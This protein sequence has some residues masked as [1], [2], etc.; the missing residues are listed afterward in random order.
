MKKLII[1]LALL[2]PVACL[3][4]G[5]PPT[6]LFPG[7]IGNTGGLA[8]Q[9]GILVTT[10]G[11]TYTLSPFQ[12]WP[13]SLRIAGTAT[14]I[15]APKN[16]GQAY[17]VT[18]TESGSIA[19]GG[20]TGT[21]VT[22]AAGA[23]VRV[24]CSDGANYVQVGSSG[25]GASVTGIRQGNGAP[26]ADTA[27]TS[28]QIATQ[29]S[30]TPQAVTLASATLTGP[31]PMG[32]TA[33]VDGLGAGTVGGGS[34]PVNM[35]IHIGPTSVPSSYT[36]ADP[37]APPSG[38]QY[39]ACSGTANVVCNWMTAS[40]GAVSSVSNSD[41]TLTCSPTTGA[42]VC[43]LNLGHAN[44]WTGVQ[45]F[46]VGAAM[47]STA[48]LVFNGTSGLSYGGASATLKVGNGTPGD[49]S[50]TLDA[51]ILN[52]GNVTGATVTATSFLFDSVLTPGSCVQAGSGG[53]LTTP[54]GACGSGGGGPGTGTVQFLPYWNSSST[55]GTSIIYQQPTT[56]WLG[57]GNSSP[58]APLHVGVVDTNPGASQNP[59]V[60]VSQSIN[61]TSQVFH[62]YTDD[63]MIIGTNNQPYASYDSRTD[64]TGSGSMDHNGGYQ[65]RATVGAT[66]T[67]TLN[68]AIG[69]IMAPDV[70]CTAC[71]INSIEGMEVDDYT[72]VSGSP[73]PPAIYYGVHVTPLTHSTTNWAFYSD[74][75]ASFF[76]GGYTSNGTSTMAT[77]ASGN[78]NI[79][80][81]N[82]AGCFCFNF[83]DSAINAGNAL[84]QTIG[85]SFSPHNAMFFG[86]NNTTVPHATMTTY[87]VGDPVELLGSQ[88]W[89]NAPTYI[90]NTLAA[91]YATL[92][93][94][95]GV[96]NVG[97]TCQMQVDTS[98]N[99][100]ATTL[101]TAT[102]SGAA[103]GVLIAPS[104]TLPSYNL[105]SLNG[106]NTNTS[107]IGILGGGTAD[108]NLYLFNTTG[109]NFSFGTNNVG[110]GNL[111]TTGFVLPSGEVFGWN[112]DT[113]LSRDSAG[114]VD[115]G[116]GTAGNKSCTFNAA[117][118]FSG[119][120]GAAAFAMNS[121]LVSGQNSS[122]VQTIA[123]NA[124]TGTITGTKYLTGVQC[125]SSA[126]PAVCGA[127]STGYITIAA[128]GSSVVVNTTAVTVQSNIFI[129]PDETLGS[130]LGVTCNTTLSSL[131]SPVVTAKTAGT[132]FTITT[133]ATILTNPACYSYI[134]VN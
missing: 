79:T 54:G 127:A 60:I 28:A 123:L 101:A 33:G 76:G 92:P 66:Y 99:T 97:T 133:S 88:D 93:S 85:K 129:Q 26:S 51:S 2:L 64:L 55:L 113:G 114:V 96:L 115:C 20:S 38:T 122:A 107:M 105:V 132:S 15:I 49:S 6:T 111:N 63:S 74:S 65:Y 57:I 34:L 109:G 13:Q 128:S 48:A 14:A 121:S 89:L 87:A 61:S 112:S 10:T 42:V 78:V 41:S 116:N 35:V 32:G 69:F 130:A 27:A 67:G 52:G 21:T 75:N 82:A 100:L 124:T 125:A 19:F 44:S 70:E 131:V 22:I 59:S 68:R 9:G 1:V 36:L 117:T 77:G 72:T 16:E 31:N 24:E 134:I 108:P 40:A 80:S 102:H 45:T 95:P 73:P 18:N 120:V 29:L 30:A 25:S 47:P 98:G 71:A 12:W 91:A 7:T 17:D 119:T 23:T 43:S 4:Q 46:S 106:G 37:G 53:L 118:F 8:L 104:A 3:A 39:Q 94:C 5:S 62:A 86:W 83:F 84:F 56:N 11:S 81:S 126:S 103:G 58:S 90:G 110:V 50:G